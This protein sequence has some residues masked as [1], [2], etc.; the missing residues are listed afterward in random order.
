[1]DTTLQE[2]L[3]ARERRVQTQNALLAQ[4][5]KPIICFTMNTPGPEKY[6]AKIAVGFWLGDR[7]LQQ[8]LQGTQ[9]L[10]RQVRYENTG[11]E[12]FYVVD[13]PAQALKQ[14]TVSLEDATPLGRLFDM[15]VLD[16][17]G[18]HLHREA[19]G[20]DSR[21]CLI[22]QENAAICARSRAH[23]LDMLLERTDA[24]LDTAV[25]QMSEMIAHTACLALEKEVTTTPKP[26]LV[27][28]NNS[29]AHR[30]M[31]IGHF[32]ASIRALK[33]YFQRVAMEGFLTQELDATEILPRLRP[34]GMEAE[35]AMLCA[36][37]GV[38]THK[39]AIFSLGL[40]CAAAGR[41]SPENWSPDN[42]CA[43]AAAMAAGVTKE[44][45]N[46]TADNAA[47]AGQQIYTAH[48]ITGVRG[49]AEAGF[50]AVLKTGLPVLQQG[51]SQGLSL[52]DAGCATLLHLLAVTDDTNLI[53]RS[54]RQ[55]QLQV[56]QSVADLVAKD[57][58]PDKAVIEQLDRDFI[59]RDLSPGGSADLL[60][61]TYFLHFL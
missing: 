50:P 1:M 19:L 42:L 43:A 48:G 28:E 59:Q 27:D 36:T 29:G 23:G 17:D 57:P 46:I 5:Q 52:N 2:I 22:C 16:A 58:Y 54:D 41:L 8:A 34:M 55:T 44:L 3:A 9:I 61:A 21:K 33:P 25:E 53:H 60:A 13:Q 18:M 7:L 24:L 30:D 11:C 37:G 31:D 15:D 49:Q 10:Y 45:S 32:F 39:G 35:Q 12:G 4:Y 14:L 47:T 26:G 40:L 56:K 20:L 38:N 51:L 6:N